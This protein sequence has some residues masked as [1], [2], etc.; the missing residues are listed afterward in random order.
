MRPWR[1]FSF[2][3]RRSSKNRDHVVGDMRRR[4]PDLGAVDQIAA[5]GLGRFGLRGEQVGAGIRLAH[6]DG[7][8]D[9]AAADPRQDVHLDVLGGVFQQHRAALAVGDEEAPGRRVGDAHFLGHHIALEEGALVAAIF[10]R[11]GHAEPAALADPSGKFRRVGVFAVRLVRI[12]GAGG[13]LLGEEGAHFLAQL[14]A[15]GRQADRIETKGC[16]HGSSLS[17]R[18]ILS[19]ISATPPAATIRRR[20]GRRPVLPSSTAQ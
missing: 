10:L 9:L 13:D 18:R 16:G 15:F 20:R 7:K 1:R 14:L 17:C 6:A 5:V 3:E 4:G 2:V 12:E 19:V 11:P 8:T